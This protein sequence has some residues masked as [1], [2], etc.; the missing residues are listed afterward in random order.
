MDGKDSALEEHRK[1]Q[2]REWAFV[3]ENP[4]VHLIRNA[5]GG[6]EDGGGVV[7]RRMSYPPGESR[8]FRDDIS[9]TV[10]WWEEGAN[11]SGSVK[12]EQMQIQGKERAKL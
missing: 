4:G 11:V 3:D 10:V 1:S 9:V 2:K 12:T 7:R 6:A 8:R 5:L